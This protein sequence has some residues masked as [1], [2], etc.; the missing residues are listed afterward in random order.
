MPSALLCNGDDRC[1]R[2]KQ[3]EAVGAAACRMRVP[4]KARSRRREPQPE[5][6]QRKI[7]FDLQPRAFRGCIFTGGVVEE[8]GSAARDEPSQSPS[9][10][11]PPKGELYSC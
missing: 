7:I 6:L 3:G 4:L 11:A 2:Q 1:L 10:T 9:V 8:N 5:Y